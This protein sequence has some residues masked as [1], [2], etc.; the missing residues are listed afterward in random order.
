MAIRPPPAPVKF[1][2]PSPVRLGAG[3]SVQVELMKPRVAA[4]ARSI[5]TFEA[6]PDHGLNLQYQGQDCNQLN[7]TA[8]AQSPRRISIS[9]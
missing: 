5:V 2:V 4:K 3:E 8:G 9:D 6:M 7:G 1:V